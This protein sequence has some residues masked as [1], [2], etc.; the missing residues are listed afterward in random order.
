M[1]RKR[2]GMAKN[3][4]GEGSRKQGDCMCFH[5]ASLSPKKAVNEE[6]YGSREGQGL[7]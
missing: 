2:G 1:R 7:L 4:P 5:M 3:I 6:T